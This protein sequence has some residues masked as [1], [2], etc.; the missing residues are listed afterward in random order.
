MLIALT[1]TLALASPTL[2]EVSL[3][4][5]QAIW[6]VEM[7]RLPGTALTAWLR[8]PNPA[9]RRR[10]VVALGRLRDA[11]RGP[12]LLR[13]LA[14]DP[15]PGVRREVAFAAGQTPDTAKL[16]LDR[17]AKETEDP[18]RDALAVALGKQGGPEAVPLLVDALDTRQ[19]EAAAEGLGRLGMR[20]VEGASGDSTARALLASLGGPFTRGHERKA[21]ALARMG[22]TSA[23]A[24]TVARLEQVAL[25]DPVATVRAWA[26][27]AWAGVASGPARAAT[28][29]RLVED[30]D[31]GVRI[32]AMRAVAKSCPPSTWPLAAGRLGDQED[33]AVR[34]EAIAAL[35]SCGAEAREVLSAQFEGGDALTRATALRA[36]VAS[37]APMELS[38]WTAPGE[39]LP[40]RIAAAE[41]MKDPD[42]LLALALQSAEAPLRSAAAGTLLG[43]ESPRLSDLLALVASTDPL[44]AQAAADGV[45]ERPD[46][47]AE[48]PLVDRLARGDL[49]APE[50][51]TFV[52][53]LAAVYATG[54]ITR[55]AP[56]AAKALQPW[57]ALPD[58]R[59]E[60]TRIAPVLAIR[61]PDPEHPSLRLPPLPE[62][63]SVRSARLFT[64]EG[65]IRIDLDPE[66]APYTVWNF[67]RLADQGYYDGVVFHRVVADFVVQ[68]GDPRGD[69]WG[70]PGWEIPDELNDLPYDVG[71]VGMALSGPDTGGSQWFITVSPQPHLEGTY[72]VFGRVSYGMRNAWA[73]QQGTRIEKVVIERVLWSGS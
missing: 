28:L 71:A 42:A 5:A 39:P 35:G 55:P 73:V 24:D 15:D 59:D 9:V 10:A 19:A 27:R 47:T 68:A 37:G 65:E 17:W 58:V 21:W 31:A 8:D 38:R 26:V 14:A 16:L 4:V 13:D 44:I 30:P 1:C 29:G 48:K 18:V 23:S 66:A 40:V 20:K 46:P 41:S 49:G 45:K 70:G 12:A 69:G 3:D 63:L 50:A 34:L 52:R 56:G 60:L 72:T 67:A 7:A 64:D 51:A 54:T 36:L 32:A 25:L 22:L 11:D 33:P 61:L 53:A 6:Q 57:L 2:D 43:A 62:V